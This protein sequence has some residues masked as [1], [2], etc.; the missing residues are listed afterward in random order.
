MTTADLSPSERT[1]CEIWT[2]V[3]GYCRPVSAWNPGKQQEH[4]D[5][6][7]FR[8]PGRELPAE[9]ARA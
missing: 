1:P 9:G 4:A 3:M 8:E 2:R 6:R 7:Y 5:R